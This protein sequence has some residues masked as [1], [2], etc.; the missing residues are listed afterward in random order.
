M[1]T[2]LTIEYD[3]SDFAGWARQPDERSV[4]EE[5]ERAL[6]TILGEQGHRRAA[7]QADGCGAHRPRRA[8]LRRRSQ[9]TR[10]RPST[11]CA[12]TACSPRTSP[13]SPRSRC[14]RTSTHAATPRAVPTAT[15][16]SRAAR[17]RVFERRRAFWWTGRLDRELLDRCAAL[18]PGRH[19]FTAFTPTET[20]HSRFVRDVA[21]ARMA[22]GKVSCSS[23]GS[24]P[25]PSC[26]T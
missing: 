5:L 15:A 4:Q 26:A 12:S 2:K 3:G 9:A 19:D 21:R 25:T 18:L 6:R 13:C 24:R 23:S 22:A 7:A 8:R 11:R 16:C 1:K 17:A 14:P 10:T 20:E